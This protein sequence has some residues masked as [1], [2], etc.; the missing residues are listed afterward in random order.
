MIQVNITNPDV[1]RFVADEVRSGRYASP[2]DLLQEAVLRMMVPA[3]PELSEEDW[4]AIEEADA[5]IDRG[6]GVER[7]VVVASLRARLQDRLR[8]RSK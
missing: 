7:D 3:S 2:A 6:E 8:S 5:E 1:E 4:R